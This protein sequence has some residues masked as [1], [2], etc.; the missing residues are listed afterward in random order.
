MRSLRPFF[1]VATG[2]IVIA[3]PIIAHHGNAEYD[4]KRPLTLKGTVTEFM[5]ASPHSKIFLNA[6]DANGSVVHWSIE[7]L[8]P[9]KLARAGWTKDAVKPGDQVTV[10]FSPAKNG[11]ATG[12]LQKVVFLDGK[13][14]GMLEH[15]Q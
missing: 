3:V 5:W 15:P 4:E 7:T 10:T 8:S 13:Q 11:S 9:G 14:L 12:F 1:A 2:L 6:K